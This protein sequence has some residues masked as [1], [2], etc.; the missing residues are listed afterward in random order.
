MVWSESVEINQRLSVDMDSNEDF[1][2]NGDNGTDEENREQKD[3]VTCPECDWVVERKMFNIHMKR[4]RN[5]SKR[6]H[7]MMNNMSECNICG[8]YFTQQF[9]A[10]HMKQMH[11]NKSNKKVKMQKIPAQVPPKRK[12]IFEPK[13]SHPEALIV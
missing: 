5:Q 10:R 13:V 12:R 7:Q 3:F 6:L 11:G 4:Q 2:P 9:L 8:N 1:M